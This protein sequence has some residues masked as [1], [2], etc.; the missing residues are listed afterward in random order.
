MLL[1]I[2]LTFAQQ[3]TT[4]RK[5]D[6]DTKPDCANCPCFINTVPNYLLGIDIAFQGIK[7]GLAS[8]KWDT[9][10]ANDNIS[11]IF[12]KKSTGCDTSTKVVNSKRE[13][14]IV[15]NDKFFSNNWDFLKSYKNE[16]KYKFHLGAYHYFYN[17]TDPELQTRTFLRDLYLTDNDLPP[18]LDLEDTALSGINSAELGENIRKW[19]EIVEQKT[20][21]TVVVYTSKYFWDKYW[22]KLSGET[23]SIL[24]EHSLWQAQ[25]NK[26]KPEP[27]LLAGWK[28]WKFWQYCGNCYIS[29]ISGEADVDVFNGTEPDLT[30]LIR[31]SIIK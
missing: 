3:D 8:V 24:F 27:D 14:V 4:K 6:C 19:I 18:V 22:S 7:G 9:V 29:G 25:Y 23:I 1:I 17:N 20:H 26:S 31:N 5:P 12:V 15:D 2:N 13:K 10:L 21:R 16:T 30:D 11:F 28:N